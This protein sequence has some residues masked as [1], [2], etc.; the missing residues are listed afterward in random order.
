VTKN[1]RSKTIEAR[2]NWS[3]PVQGVASCYDSHMSVE[4]IKDC[5]QN[6]KSVPL[7]FLENVVSD[8][9]NI[10]YNPIPARVI[11]LTSGE[12]IA[13]TKDGPYL[14]FGGIP[15]KEKRIK[16]DAMGRSEKW[17][18]VRDHYPSEVYALCRCGASSGMPYC[19]GA[20][21]RIVFDGTETASRKTYA[22]NS[23]QYPAAEGVELRQ[24]PALCVGAGF[25]HSAH[26]ISRTVKKEKTLGIATQQI[27][28]CP[29]GSLTLRINGEE[30]EP[31]YNKEIAVT[32]ISNKIGPLWVRGGIPVIASDGFEY[33]V[34]NRVALCRCG[35]SNNK[36]FC[37]SAHL[38]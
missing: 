3:K 22:E 16:K 17:E 8:S 24:D 35:K 18:D 33:E 27:C 4:Y 26:N 28:D 5:E 13:V 25:C 11:M 36:P 34:R 37:D 6:Q 12:R 14:V 19:D 32:S 23:T 7:K 1:V 30:I 21:T 10:L 15:L 20:H 31:E 38:R 9:I 2:G 29:G